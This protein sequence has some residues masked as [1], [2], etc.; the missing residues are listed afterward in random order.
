LLGQAAPTTLDEIEISTYICTINGKV[1]LW[2][3][4]QVTKDLVTLKDELQGLKR[5]RDTDK[6]QIL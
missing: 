4:I 5:G 3:L 1:N 2:V 6:V